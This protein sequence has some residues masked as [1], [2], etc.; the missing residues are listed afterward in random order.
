MV[1]N[2]DPTNLKMKKEITYICIKD[3]N[4][5]KYKFVKGRI[6]FESEIGILNQ[7]NFKDYF[8]I[9][10]STNE[11]KMIVYRSE[12]CQSWYECYKGSYMGQN[13]NYCG[14]CGKLCNVIEVENGL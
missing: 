13:F 1:Q 11:D 10:N 3:F 9:N 8:K 12:C 7:S 14:C 2:T 5:F 6:Y 4:G